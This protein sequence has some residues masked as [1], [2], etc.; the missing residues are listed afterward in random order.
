MKQLLIG[1]LMLIPT[2]VRS[3]DA[4]IVNQYGQKTG[5]RVQGAPT[6]ASPVE[7]VQLADYLNRNRQEASVV[8]GLS[9]VMNAGLSG[10]ERGQLIALRE[11]ELKLK[12]EQLKQSQLALE[13]LESSPQDQVLIKR[14]V[15]D[16]CTYTLAEMAA[17]TEKI[18]KKICTENP[19]DER[20]SGDYSDD[21]VGLVYD[22][23]VNK[24]LVLVPKSY[25]YNKKSKEKP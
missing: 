19:K 14:E 23:F 10:Y 24:E 9:S 12:Q 2:I 13:Q 3:Q 20:C 6:M 17:R 1:A 7:M 25:F 5:Y 18:F 15:V 21:M 22:A 16:A 4:D 8:G 11:T